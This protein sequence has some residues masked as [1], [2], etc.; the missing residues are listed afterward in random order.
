MVPRAA[1]DTSLFSF[2]NSGISGTGGNSSYSAAPSSRSSNCANFFSS[3][4]LTFA[5]ILPS[6]P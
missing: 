6:F 5:G 4:T 2:K 3:E 1:P